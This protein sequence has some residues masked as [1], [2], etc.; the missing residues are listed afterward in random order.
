[1][2][3]GIESENLGQGIRIYYINA[4]WG[5]LLQLSMQDFD[6]CGCV[7]VGFALQH[8]LKVLTSEKFCVS[9]RFSKLSSQANTHT[10]KLC[11]YCR[12]QKKVYT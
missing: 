10:K 8:N 6:V 3:V 4:N 5:Q 1:M 12:P 11:F 7:C 9:F 2:R